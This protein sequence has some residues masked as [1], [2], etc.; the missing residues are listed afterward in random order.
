MPRTK[1]TVLHDAASNI[2]PAEFAWP[3][4]GPD[5]RT[6]H[7]RSKAI[8]CQCCHQYPTAQNIR[9]KAIKSIQRPPK[10]GVTYQKTKPKRRHIA[11]APGQA[12][13]T[14]TG[15]LAGDIKADIS[16]KRA[17]VYTDLE[18]AAPL[19]FGTRN[20]AARPFMLPAMEAEREAWNRRIK[21]VIDEAV[22]GIAR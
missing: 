12:P 2:S 21:R 6:R 9:T 18:Y 20:M 7:A 4:V 5:T 22:K 10:T 8:R 19:E 3:P 1:P 15:R 13:A 14:D 11:S 16:G 17:E